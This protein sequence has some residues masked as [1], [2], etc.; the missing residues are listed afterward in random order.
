MMLSLVDLPRLLVNNNLNSSLELQQ[1]Y[2]TAVH[3]ISVS[4]DLTCLALRLLGVCVDF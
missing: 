1:P 4:F 2:R 3:A